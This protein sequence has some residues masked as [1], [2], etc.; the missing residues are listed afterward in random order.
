MDGSV[1]F[2]VAT[3]NL[4]GVMD[5]WQERRPL[6]QECLKQLDADVLCFQEVLTGAAVGVGPCG[7]RPTFRPQVVSQQ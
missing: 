2:S 3:F 5:R 1:R 7:T 4:R 6:L